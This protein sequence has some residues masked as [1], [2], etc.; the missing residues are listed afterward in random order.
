MTSLTASTVLPWYNRV[1]RE[2]G[3]W[4]SFVPMQDLNEEWTDTKLYKKYGLTA[5]EIAFIESM[6][7]L[8]DVEQEISADDAD[9]RR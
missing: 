3:V 4:I 8:M 7:R 9:K 6:V 2:E 1:A 5:D